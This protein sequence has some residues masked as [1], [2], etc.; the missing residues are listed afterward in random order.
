[1]ESEGLNQVWGLKSD[2]WAHGHYRRNMRIS[3]GRVMQ[4]AFAALDDWQQIPC[5]IKRM[6]ED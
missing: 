6:C 4:E 2:L 5:L 1:M 3:L